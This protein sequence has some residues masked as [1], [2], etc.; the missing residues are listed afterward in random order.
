MNMAKNAEKTIQDLLQEQ[1]IIT[2]GLAG[3]PQQQI[4]KIVG[5]DIVRVSRIVKHL[6]K[7]EK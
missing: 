4:R 5:G 2:M 7:K 3:V 6:K 1:M